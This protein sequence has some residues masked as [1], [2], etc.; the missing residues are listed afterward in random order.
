[1][2]DKPLATVAYQQRARISATIWL[3]MN[4]M[5]IEARP[6]FLGQAVHVVAFTVAMESNNNNI[7]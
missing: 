1:L 4:K 2:Q 6:W 7:E 5:L 3:L